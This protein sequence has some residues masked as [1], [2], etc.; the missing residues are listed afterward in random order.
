MSNPHSLWKGKKYR[1]TTKVLPIVPQSRDD[2][3]HLTYILPDVLFRF[4]PVCLCACWVEME[5]HHATCLKPACV[6]PPAFLGGDKM[7]Q[8]T[9]QK[10]GLSECPGI[11]PSSHLIRITYP[12]QDSES[13]SQARTQALYISRTCPL[14]SPSSLLTLSSALGRAP[15]LRPSFLLFV[16]ETPDVFCLQV[17]ARFSGTF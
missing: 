14:A 17:C 12:G 8:G 1:W 16:T 13:W 11:W 7:T 5:S 15:F 2:C 10:I 4:V 3:Q 6:P 9:G